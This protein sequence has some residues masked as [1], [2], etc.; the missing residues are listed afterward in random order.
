MQ[1]KSIPVVPLCHDTKPWF[2]LAGHFP[3]SFKPSAVF[4]WSIIIKMQ[5]WEFRRA[6]AGLNFHRAKTYQLDTH[7]FHH[8]QG[9]L[10]HKTAPKCTWKEKKTKNACKKGSDVKLCE[11]NATSP[12]DRVS[13][14]Q[15]DA[16]CWRLQN[17]SVAARRVFGAFNRASL[18]LVQTC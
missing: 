1:V 2:P 10:K 18:M 7:A 11:N 8:N 3:V 17:R 15:A 9:T 5:R 6:G 13:C 4:G 12:P 16:H 14:L